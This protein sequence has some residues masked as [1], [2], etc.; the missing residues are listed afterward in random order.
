MAMHRFY[1]LQNIRIQE[2]LKISVSWFKSFSHRKSWNT[3]QHNLFFSFK[4]FVY[5]FEWH[6]F[7]KLNR[8]LVIYSSFNQQSIDG[9]VWIIF[10]VTVELI[11]GVDSIAFKLVIF[12]FKSFH[13]ISCLVFNIIQSRPLNIFEVFFS[14]VVMIFNG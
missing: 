11:S 1:R 14:S 3:I 13:V 12:I 7:W 9:V 6:Y 2:H 4:D 10:V 5:L 8:K